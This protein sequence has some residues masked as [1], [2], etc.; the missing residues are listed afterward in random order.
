M[1]AFCFRVLYF[2]G[3]EERG[4]GGGGGL[5]FVIVLTV[6][7]NLLIAVVRE[8]RC[9]CCACH[10]VSWTSL[11]IGG[12]L[13]FFCMI[14]RRRSSVAPGLL[15]GRRVQYSRVAASRHTRVA[16]Q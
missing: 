9:D 3:R 10:V 4:E 8:N 12:C 2:D 6:K 15:R 11:L 14:Y 13:N 7:R 5:L 16:V 1:K